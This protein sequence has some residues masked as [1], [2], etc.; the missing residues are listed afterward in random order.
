[1]ARLLLLFLPGLVAVGTVHGMFMDK[2]ASKKLC[3]DD[4][5]VCKDFLNAFYYVVIK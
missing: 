5:C 4:E 2:L 3:A 1:M